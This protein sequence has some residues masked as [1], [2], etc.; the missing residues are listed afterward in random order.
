MDTPKVADAL[1]TAAEYIGILIVMYMVIVQYR[2]PYIQVLIA[3]IAVKFV[4]AFY[5]NVIRHRLIGDG[6]S[7]DKGGLLP[8]YGLTLGIMDMAL[9]FAAFIG[10]PIIASYRFSA[11]EVGGVLVTGFAAGMA[12]T[13]V[14]QRL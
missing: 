14:I 7:S 4:A 3:Y 2:L 11:L 10:V 12:S 9:A 1:L 8:S 5:N 13:A 6:K